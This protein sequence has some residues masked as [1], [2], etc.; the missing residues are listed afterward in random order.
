MTKSQLKAQHHLV[1]GGLSGLTS[2]VCLQPLDL[3]KTRL[4]QGRSE[5]KR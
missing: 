3:L 5:G 4:Q 2:A 1:S